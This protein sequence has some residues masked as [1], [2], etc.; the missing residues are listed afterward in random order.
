M[1]EHIFNFVVFFF[2]FYKKKVQLQK[3]E[4]QHFLISKKYRSVWAVFF[5]LPACKKKHNRLEQQIYITEICTVDDTWKVHQTLKTGPVTEAINNTA[6]A[7]LS[8]NLRAESRPA[9]TVARLHLAPFV[10]KASPMRGCQ[11]AE[12]RG[13]VEGGTLQTQTGAAKQ[14]IAS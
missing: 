11:S 6:G 8:N 14:T 1:Q 3:K 13:G 5:C 12:L 4:I 2:S 7:E 10:R 9:A